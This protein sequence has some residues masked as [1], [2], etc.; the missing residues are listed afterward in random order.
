MI[1]LLRSIALRLVLCGGATWGVWRLGFGGGTVFMAGLFGVAL[2]RPLLELAS[3]V[4]HQMRR[5]NWRELEGRHY[6][7][8]GVPIK[9]TEDADRQRWVRLADV[10]KAIG[11]TA[12]DAALQ[13]AYPAGFQRIGRGAQAHLG[14]EALLAHLAKERSPE[15]I[16]LRLWVEREIV[17]PA[18]RERERFG[19][20]TAPSEARPG[21]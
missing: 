8:R 15:A 12:G 1:P 13:V 10:R 18:R 16:R 6:V 7:F 3:E 2:A 4:R 19:I 20:R 21:E 17:F 9:V 11:F 14:D 5:A